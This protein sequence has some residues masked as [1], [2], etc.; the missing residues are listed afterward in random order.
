[1]RILRGLLIFI[2]S[3]VLTTFIIGLSV[4]IA[5]KDVVQNQLMGEMVKQMITR[6]KKDDE[7]NIKLETVD[8]IFSYSE[9]N[10]IINSAIIDYANYID[11][12]SDGI[13]EKTVDMIIDF[14]V[15][16]KSDLE[17]ITGEEIKIDDIRSSE[18]RE[19]LIESV[20][21]SINQ[22]KIDK[23]SPVAIVVSSYS[24]VTSED[25]KIKI[26]AVAIVLVLMIIIT[27]WS[28][29]KWM[30]PIGSVL[31]TSGVVVSLL[32]I[33]MEVATTFINETIGVTIKLNVN[34]ILII[35][36]IE[37]L[38]GVVML[39]IYAIINS[40]VNKKKVKKSNQML[41]D[42]EE[43]DEVEEK[44]QELISNQEEEQIEQ[45]QETNYENE[46]IKDVNQSQEFKNNAEQK[47]ED[48]EVL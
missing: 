35:G 47:E 34:L 24:K 10:D 6:E 40:V 8:K 1:M 37:L 28:L 4:T 9:T 32:Y 38:S 14:C 13:S 22:V 3:F 18:V 21:K 15:E 11:G 12:T 31:I 36:V 16:H 27:S 30:K 17:E 46:E 43:D 41:V 45:K 5:V 33:I 7:D 23:S 42:D 19:E 25:F 39:V 29:Y 20:N 26:L 44:Q 48:I 2:F